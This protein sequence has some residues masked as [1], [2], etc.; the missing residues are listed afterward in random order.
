MGGTEISDDIKFML[1]PTRIWE[2][3]PD[4]DVL[5]VGE[6]ET[7]LVEILDAISHEEPLPRRR[8]GV[9]LPGDREALQ[10][11]EV[12]Y[13][14]LS[15]LAE[16]RYDI[17]D[18]EQYWVPEPVVLYSPTRGCYW[19]KCT[20]CD[21][22]LNTTS[23]TSPSRI[24]P[25]DKAVREIHQITTFAKTLYFSVD[26]MSPSYLRKIARAIQE[27]QLPIQWSAELR[28][29]RSF[30]KGLARELKE[31]GCIAISFGYESG[32]QRVL[33]LIN[34]GVN[35]QL[36][37]GILQELSNVGI[38][39]QMMGFI[40]FPGETADEAFSTFVFLRQY[41]DCWTLAGIGNFILTKGSIV[42][43][44]HKDFG[45]QEICVYSGDDIARELYWIDNDGQTRLYGDTRTPAIDEIA[46]LARP[47]VDDR[48]FVGGIDSSHSIL[49][50]AK[51]GPSLVPPSLRT[52]K[53]SR[54]LLEIVRYQTPLRQVEEFFEKADI[55]E[56]YDSY[57]EQR[58][59]LKFAQL[60]EWLRRYPDEQATGKEDQ[61]V[62]QETLEIYP[63]GQYI[64]CSS[65]MIE[66][67]REASDAY[68][69]VKE[70]LLRA[71]GAL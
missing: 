41:R 51:Y 12:R 44:R 8:P 53:P 24:R 58:Q 43:K 49:Y 39:V 37:P 31:A 48:P 16:P 11:P 42:A 36:V 55:R 61:G 67:E 71:T 1:D 45:I 30:M 63:N 35:L 46:K 50:F 13:E 33:N 70:L 20:F 15:T 10:Q 52:Q 2:L 17:W 26:A 28:L 25:I 66:I 22:G 62:Q 65:Q 19:N 57:R 23:P 38:G 34:K 69:T 47:F 56:Y 5:V 54:S 68:Q 59:P 14:N 29:E 40:G 6:G 9:L 27:N 60:I 4:C 7:A 18:W 3:F 64:T 32:A 21:Y